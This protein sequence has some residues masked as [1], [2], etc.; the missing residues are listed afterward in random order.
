M[1]DDKVPTEHGPV[2]SAEWLAFQ[3]KYWHERGR[4]HDDQHMTGIA[5][6]QEALRR[7]Q[8]PGTEYLEIAERTLRGQTG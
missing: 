6:H 5:I 1:C 8:H 4:L 7:A 2:G 3:I